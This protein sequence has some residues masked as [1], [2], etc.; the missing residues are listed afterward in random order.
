M[1]VC[2][3]AICMYL[4]SPTDPFVVGGICFLRQ[5]TRETDDGKEEKGKGAGRNIIEIM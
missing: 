2:N 5:Q 1:C 4:S 3:L